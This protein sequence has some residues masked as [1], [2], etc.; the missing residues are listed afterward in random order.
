MEVTVKECIKNFKIYYPTKI[1]DSSKLAELCSKSVFYTL[2]H[3]P[4]EKFHPRIGF[5]KS[6]IKGD[7]FCIYCDSCN[8]R[9]LKATVHTLTFDSKEIIKFL[10]F[11]CSGKKYR[12][13]TASEKKAFQ[14]IQDPESYITNFSKFSYKD[15]LAFLEAEFLREQ[16]R[17]DLTR[18]Y[19]F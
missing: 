17:E 10:C 12:R 4:E 16:V 8:S 6:N 18:K 14:L 19:K 2:K 7:Y 11:R 1:T 5:I 3:N 9:C 15:T 13:S